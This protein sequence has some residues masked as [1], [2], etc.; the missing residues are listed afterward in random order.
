MGIRDFS[1]LLR[2]VWLKPPS[3]GAPVVK[4]IRRGEY[5]GRKYVEITNPWLLVSF[6]HYLVPLI[7]EASSGGCDICMMSHHAQK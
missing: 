2:A 5:H 4:S 6:K 7:F 1:L 3:G